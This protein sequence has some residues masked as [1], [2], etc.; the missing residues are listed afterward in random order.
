MENKKQIWVE[1]AK[2]WHPMKDMTW[3]KLMNQL[4]W[5]F[6]EINENGKVVMTRNGYINQFDF[7]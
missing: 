3:D 7:R 1:D 4:G 5:R 2:G 6:M